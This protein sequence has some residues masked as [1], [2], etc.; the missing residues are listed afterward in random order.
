MVSWKT[1]KGKPL[2]NMSCIESK[3]Y[4]LSMLKLNKMVCL[5][6]CRTLHKMLITN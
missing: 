1:Y 3:M 2:N 5:Y 6:Y 4:N